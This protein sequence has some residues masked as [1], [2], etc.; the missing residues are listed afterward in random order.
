MKRKYNYRLYNKDCFAFLSSFDIHKKHKFDLCLTSPPFDLP[1]IHRDTAIQ[2]LRRACKIVVMFN[3]SKNLDDIIS[4]HHPKKV[5]IWN[6][7]VGMGAFRYE[8]IFIWTKEPV[9][10]PGRIWSDVLSFNPIPGKEQLTQDEN[11]L[12]LYVQLLR[13]FPKEVS[14]LD[15]FTGSGTSGAACSYLMQR[16]P[17]RQFTGLEI[18]PV[19]FRIAKKRIEKAYR[20]ALHLRKKG[21]EIEYLEKRKR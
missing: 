21:L 12:T 10:G 20:R 6:K 17:L 1:K 19:R 4:T 9:N 15:P 3:S 5:L 2:L 16:N 18:D 7:Q 8:P 14:V 13:Y 11:P